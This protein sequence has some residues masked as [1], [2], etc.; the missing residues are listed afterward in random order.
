M[1]FILIVKRLVKV[2]RLFNFGKRIKSDLWTK[3]ANEKLNS[4]S[5][6]S[7]DANIG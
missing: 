2:C 3:M 6:M 4:L 5:I 7:I 1:I